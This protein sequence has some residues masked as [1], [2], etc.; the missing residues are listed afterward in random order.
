M[1]VCSLT[2]GISLPRARIAGVAPIFKTLDP[3]EDPI[4]YVIS[5]NIKRRDLNQ[6]QKAMG[7]ALLNFFSEKNVGREIP[8]GH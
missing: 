8:D 7:A 1:K 4:A 5:A 2:G 6:S 3:G